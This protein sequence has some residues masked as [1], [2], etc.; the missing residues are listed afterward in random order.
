MHR[1]QHI[2]A[3]LAPRATPALSSAPAAKQDQ[4]W[5]PVF[6]KLKEEQPV[7]KSETSKKTTTLEEW[8]SKKGQTLGSS[9]WWTMSQERIDAFALVT[10]DFQWIHGSDA[11]KKGS[12]FGGPIAHGFLVLSMVTMFVES[13]LPKLK[14]VKMGVNLGL[15]RVR[16]VSPVPAGKRIRATVALK[17]IKDV[18]NNGVESIYEVTIEVEGGK[19]PACVIEWVTRAYF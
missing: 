17:S 19:K 2:A 12:P 18:E 3:Q 7:A 5:A 11:K 1:L 6:N 16:W 10:Q 14:G 8:K 13:V 9:E 4:D 15:N